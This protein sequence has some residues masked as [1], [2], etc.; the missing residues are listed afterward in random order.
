[1]KLVA[2]AKVRRAQE[3]VI[4]GRPFAENLVKVSRF[5]ALP[6]A[7]AA[8]GR[9]AMH[10]GCQHALATH[11]HAGRRPAGAVRRQPAPARGGCGLPSVRC[12]PREDG[13]ADHPDRRPRPV[14][15]LQQLHHQ[16][17]ARAAISPHAPA[18]ARGGAAA[19]AAASSRLPGSRRQAQRA[20]P[21]GSR[22]A[23]TQRWRGRRAGQPRR[24]GAPGRGGAA[25][26]ADAPPQPA[27]QRGAGGLQIPCP[28]QLQRRR[29]VPSSSRAA[30][31]IAPVPICSRA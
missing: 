22:Q 2:A 19:A 12:P 27:A 10:I 13:A 3:A 1:M 4:N 11:A 5:S 26:G 21:A 14:R 29:A 16:E 30:A 9:S 8:H 6:Q 20:A 24:R 23:G 7:R 31:G 17:G 28:R 25:R 18:S 15:R